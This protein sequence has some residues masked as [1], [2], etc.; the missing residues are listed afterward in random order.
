MKYKSGIIVKLLSILAFWT[1]LLLT[2]HSVKGWYGAG[3]TPGWNNAYDGLTGMVTNSVLAPSASYT[4]N[5]SI[6]LDFRI[7]NPSGNATESEK[8][9]YLKVFRVLHSPLSQNLGDPTSVD[10]IAMSEDNLFT[11]N[12]NGDDSQMPYQTL[13]LGTLNVFAGETQDFSADVSIDTAG[14]Y[15]Y[16]LTDLS[17]ESSFIPGHIYAAGF[18]RIVNPPQTNTLSA[19]TSTSGGEGDGL[20]T[21]PPVCSDQAPKSAP[22]I[23]NFTTGTNSITITWSPAIDPVTYYLVAY[24]TA[25]GHYTFG[26]P[27]VG[28]KDVR[29]Y[30]ISGLSGDTTYYVVVRAGNGCM[31]GPFSNE[32]SATPG[33]IFIAGPATGF[34]EGVL[35]I[36]TDTTPEGTPTGTVEGATIDSS[37]PICRWS[38]PMLLLAFIASM[39]HGNFIDKKT[40]L[41]KAFLTGILIPIIAHIIFV[42]I[43]RTCIHPATLSEWIILDLPAWYCRYFL[44]VAMSVYL[45]V[46]AGLHLLYQRKKASK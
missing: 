38:I 14:Y 36:A 32:I 35:G 43:N 9:I 40:P 30:T 31:P 34:Q 44:F 1:L 39:A 15:Q 41:G 24:G 37:C 6:P 13:S 23:T 12:K 17:E 26:N 33:G 27:D 20:S 22:V 7:T 21:K 46:L 42:L 19:S 29:S 18:L 5:A 10:S 45:I 3:V 4:V 8:S 25:S 28:G 2:P 16:D 11:N